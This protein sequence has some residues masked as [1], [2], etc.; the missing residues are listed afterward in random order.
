MKITVHSSKAVKPAY[1][2]GSLAAPVAGV[3]PLSVFDKANFDTYVSVIYAFRPPAP[4]NAVLEAG[5]SKALAEYP[6]WA[7]RFGVDDD[8]NRAI[9]LNGA[10]ARFVEATADVA[11]DSVM[12]LEPTPKVVS[13]HPCGDDAEEVM[14]IQV[15]R[16]ACGSLVVGF[17]A[18]HMVSDGRATSNFF[19]A[20]SQAT[21][22]VAIHPVPVH[23]RAS[24][25]APRD[26]PLV[27]CEHRSVEFKSSDKLNDDRDDDGHAAADEVVTHKVH[28][29]REFIA[30]LKTLASAGGQHHRSYSTLQ[31]V[32]AHLWRCI[33]MARGLDGREAT[34]ASIAVDG[35]AR[36]S[37]PVPDGYT[38]NVVLWARPTATARELV[39]MPLHHAVG[40]VNKA[41]ARINDGYFKSFIDF[42]SS[43]AVEKERLVSSA[44][45]SEMV[46]TPNIEVDSWLR[47]PFYDLDFGSGQ[48]FSFTPSYL[49]VE[50]LLILLPSF[51]GD[52]SV[53]AY[54]PLFRR[55]MDVF[56]SCCYVLPELS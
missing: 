24:F 36:M 27:D 29:S 3:V 31:C 45:A 44:D 9:V 54:V 6:E 14:L 56:K 8:G 13:L 26:P 33:T 49:P 4:A 43:G 17:T 19:L 53:D 2:G 16:F 11:L 40:L 42:A 22:G 55:D 52:G 37:R 48:P 25:F 39:T 51:S 32:V 18:H 46:L 28:F 41:V 21:R 30:K 10:G 12:P 5:L 20:W 35:R 38:G 50:G 23:D 47:L 7:G 15:T 34:S 1:D